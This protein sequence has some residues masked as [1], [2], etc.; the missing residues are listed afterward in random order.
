[1][2][3]FLFTKGRVSTVILSSTFSSL[4]TYYKLVIRVTSLLYQSLIVLQFF[5]YLG[6]NRPKMRSTLSIVLLVCLLS[7]M[8]ME[9][10]DGHLAPLLK[11]KGL[12]KGVTGKDAGGTALAAVISSR[13]LGL[14]LKAILFKPLLLV[15]LAKIKLA[16]LLGKPL[17]LLAIKK[18]LLKAVLGKLL[19]KIPLILLKGKAL[20]VKMLALKFALV[21]KGLLGLKAPLAMLF[22]GACALGSGLGLAVALGATLHKLKEHETHEEEYSSYEDQGYALPPPRPVYGPPAYSAPV[23]YPAA[24]SYSAAP[25][26]SPAPAYSS[27]VAT[28]A[29]ASGASQGVYGLDTISQSAGL[30]GS[31]FGTSGFSNFGSSGAGLG[32]GYA[33]GRRK[34]DTQ[35]SINSEDDNGDDSEEESEGSEEET[36]DESPED[37]QIEFEAARTNGNAYLYMAAQFDEQ[38]CGRRLM[39]EVYQKPHDSLSEDEILLQEIFGL[40]FLSFRQIFEA[41]HFI[42]LMY[43]TAIHCLS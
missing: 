15:A 37:I 21:T 36:I 32:G 35:S 19:L 14:G 6:L 4:I 42:N 31:N 1:M 5:E 28:Y 38:S 20:L 16:L 3:D 25:A 41:I 18:L 8:Y 23:S 7:A 10:A 13:K 11:G 30:G 22:L 34:R 26:Y 40:A 29:Q 43:F 12:G 17:A 39:C 24:P 9:Q 27:P 33:G 2:I